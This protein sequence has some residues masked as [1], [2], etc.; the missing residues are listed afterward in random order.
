MHIFASSPLI[1]YTGTDK[2]LVAIYKK[3]NELSAEDRTDSVVRILSSKK[4]NAN[5]WNIKEGANS[6]SKTSYGYA[7]HL[8]DPITPT[9]DLN[10]GAPSEVYFSVSGYPSANLFN[11]YWDEYIAQIADKDSK[12]LE[13]YVY[14]TPLDIAQLDFSKAVFIDGIRFRINKV[15]DYDYTNNDLVKVELLKIV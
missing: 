3:S 4:K 13:C 12:I 5:S 9:K 2:I 6:Y 7:G 10:F 8:D 1:K 15:S 14:L 11:E